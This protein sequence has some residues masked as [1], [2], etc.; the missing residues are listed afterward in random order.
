MSSG[1]DTIYQIRTEED[2]DAALERAWEIFQADIGSPEGEELERL[3]TLIEAYEDE[4][5]PIGLPSPIGAIEFNL[6]RLG[7]TE[8]DLVSII[9]SR[10]KVKE[11]LTGKR[12]ITAP[13]ARDL[14]KLLD[15]P[16]AVLLQKSGDA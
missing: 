7:L 4:H 13:M 15:I 10:L 16:E 11:V 14:G 1:M 9:G 3:V 6:D 2:Y 5:Y 8:H 12:E